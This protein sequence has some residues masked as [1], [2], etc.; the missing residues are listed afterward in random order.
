VIE[1]D[2]MNPDSSKVVIP[3]LD[4]GIHGF[5][6]D[7]RVKPG[8]DAE[9]ATSKLRSIGRSGRWGAVVRDA[10]QGGAFCN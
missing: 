1:S 7:G 10:G 8:H 2:A 9:E 6:V 4:P 3:G 5:F